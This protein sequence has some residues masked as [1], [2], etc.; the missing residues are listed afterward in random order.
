MFLGGQPIETCCYYFQNFPTALC[1]K[2]Y[3]KKVSY[4]KSTFAV[5]GVKSASHLV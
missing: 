2:N 1:V 4:R 5:D 3:Y